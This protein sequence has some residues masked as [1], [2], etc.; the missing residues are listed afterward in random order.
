MKIEMNAA[1]VG[2]L[3]TILVEKATDLSIALMRAK[4][5]SDK[6]DRYFKTVE[7]EAQFQIVEALISKFAPGTKH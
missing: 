4:K 6:N 2:A 5:L 3:V 1:E 7:I